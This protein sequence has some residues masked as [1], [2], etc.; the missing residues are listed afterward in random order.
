MP[1]YCGSAGM[2]PRRV[3]LDM[4]YGE[5]LELSP[6]ATPGKPTDDEVA[7]AHAA[8][9]KALQSLFDEHKAAFGYGD[10]QLKIM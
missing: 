2:L 7:V 1:L 3:P 9:I 8:Y 6:T 10:R 4:V 5:P